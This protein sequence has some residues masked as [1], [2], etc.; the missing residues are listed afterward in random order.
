VAP[1]A[2]ATVTAEFYYSINYMIDI[3]KLKIAMTKTTVDIIKYDHTIIPKGL[4][5]A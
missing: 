2:R 4:K 1:K 5:L 3:N